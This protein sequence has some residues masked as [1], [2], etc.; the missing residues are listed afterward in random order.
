MNNQHIKRSE[1]VYIRAE[2]LDQLPSGQKQVRILAS[3]AD[4]IRFYTDEHSIIRTPKPVSNADRIRVMSDEELAEFIMLS[5]EMEFGVCEC[6]EVFRGRG[7]YTHCGTENG[8]C[9]AEL[10]CGAFKKWLQQPAEEE[11]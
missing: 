3:N 11:T 9:T 10:R 2:V 4:G 6:C 1:L 7:A 8:W 5:P